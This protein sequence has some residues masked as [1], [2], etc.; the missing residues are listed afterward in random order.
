MSKK[1]GRVGVLIVAGVA[2]YAL[3]LLLFEVRR[4]R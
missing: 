2:L 1:R 4:R 3:A